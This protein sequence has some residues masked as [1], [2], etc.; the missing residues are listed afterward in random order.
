MRWDLASQKIACIVLE[1]Q[2][3][4][5]FIAM[6]T[7]GFCHK[8]RQDVHSSAVLSLA[9][10]RPSLPPR[11]AQVVADIKARFYPWRIPNTLP[12][13]GWQYALSADAKGSAWSSEPSQ[14]GNQMHT[15]VKEHEQ[16]TVIFAHAVCL[17]PI[18]LPRSTS[19]AFSLAHLAVTWIQCASDASPIASASWLRFGFWKAV[20]FRAI[21]QHW[22]TNLRF[23]PWFLSR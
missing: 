19:L 9:F 4:T 5:A 3:L 11:P 23:F 17:P 8:L 20:A 12:I 18:F 10:C 7:R 21:I 13:T 1:P 15:A 16:Y 2:R 14:F 22:S 6:G